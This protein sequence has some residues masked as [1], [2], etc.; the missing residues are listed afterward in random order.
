M[1]CSNCGTENRVGAKFCTECATPLAQACP[2]CGT[3]NPPTAK[4]FD[5]DKSGG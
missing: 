5:A 3:A 4:F 2:N 1:I